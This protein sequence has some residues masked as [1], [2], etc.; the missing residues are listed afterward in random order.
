[1]P[2]TLNQFSFCLN[3]SFFFSFRSNFHNIDVKE[4]VKTIHRVHWPGCRP[5]T[6]WEAQPIDKTALVWTFCFESLFV[7]WWVKLLL[8]LKNGW[9]VSK[10]CKGSEV[11]SIPTKGPSLI[12]LTPYWGPRHIMHGTWFDVHVKSM[13]NPCN[14][15]EKSMLQLW[16]IHVTKVGPSP[17]WLASPLGTLWGG[18]GSEGCALRLLEKSSF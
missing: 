12:N 10:G 3:Y 13:K 6:Y 9:K 18:R 14:K 8:A 4:I 16:Q 15:F 17:V 11:W 1:M 5:D 7:N 2:I